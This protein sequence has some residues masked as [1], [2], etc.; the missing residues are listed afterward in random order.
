M[1]LLVFTEN[2]FWDEEPAGATLGWFLL[3]LDKMLPEVAQ[4]A[5]PPAPPVLV[6]THHLESVDLLSDAHVP[7]SFDCPVTHDAWEGLLHQLLHTAVAVVTATT[8]GLKRV[9]KQHDT[10]RADE[11]AGR[12]GHKCTVETVVIQVAAR[13]IVSHRDDVST[14]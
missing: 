9:A 11:L 2:I 5:R 8:L 14:W 7:E 3:T 13:V 12:F 4:V 6:G 1:Q 10:N